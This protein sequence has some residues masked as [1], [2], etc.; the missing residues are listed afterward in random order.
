MDEEDE[1]SEEDD[2]AGDLGK[3]KMRV[4]REVLLKA[5][6]SDR[7]GPDVAIKVDEAATVRRITVLVEGKAQVCLLI[8]FPSW[9]WIPVPYRVVK[10]SWLVV[11]M[12]GGSYRQ[13][14]GSV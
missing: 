5:R 14:N 13:L 10:D 12:C 3:G 8:P 6:L 1:E 4:G 7:G 11:D 9:Q 2:A